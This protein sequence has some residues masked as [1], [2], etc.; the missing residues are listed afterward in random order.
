MGK[1]TLKTAGSDRATEE[2]LGK[3]GSP[4]MENKQE[5]PRVLEGPIEANTLAEQERHCTCSSLIGHRAFS[6]SG[7]PFTGGTVIFDTFQ[8]SGEQG[9]LSLLMGLH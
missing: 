4:G 2:N 7:L 1:Q 8:N 5:G 6:K 9:L 3:N